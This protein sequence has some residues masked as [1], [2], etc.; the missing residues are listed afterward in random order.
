M[1][2]KTMKAYLAWPVQI[3]GHSLHSHHITLKYLGSLKD[4]PEA[5][6]S[7]LSELLHGLDLR[8]NESSAIT[9][10]P[11]SF[12]GGA[13]VMVLQGAAGPSS[14]KANRILESVRADDFGS[15][16]PHIT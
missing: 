6:M 9:W 15:W 16:N 3:G 10:T 1:K 5:L 12:R 2:R 14:I 8:L 11:A 13:K 4:S 7:K